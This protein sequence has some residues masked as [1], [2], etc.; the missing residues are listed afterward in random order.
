MRGPPTPRVH[1]HTVAKR[2]MYIGMQKSRVHGHLNSQ[3][4]MTG[5]RGNPSGQQRSMMHF[6][7]TGNSQSSSPLRPNSQATKSKHISSPT[8]PRRSNSECARPATHAGAPAAAPA[9][10]HGKTK[11][12]LL[13]RL[14]S[15]RE[16]WMAN[17][18]WMVPLAGT[19]FIHGSAHVL[20][21][22]PLNAVDSLSCGTAD[23][24]G[25]FEKYLAKRREVTFTGYRHY[26]KHPIA[27]PR[28]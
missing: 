20:L 9:Q 19:V 1:G 15:I 6:V 24:D 4:A 17:D 10:D 13:Q 2:P 16:K 21:P 18:C 14:E 5:R 23:A 26:Q 11:S 7:I 28:A 22:P 8:P 25:K 12:V 3:G 27:Y